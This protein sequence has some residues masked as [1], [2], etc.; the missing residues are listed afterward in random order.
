MSVHDEVLA[1]MH[2]M[3]ARFAARGLTLE[4]PPASSRL[5]GTKYVAVEMGKSLSGRF[6][7]NPAFGNPL[8]MYQGGMLGA[9]F[10]E[11]FGPLTYMAAQRPVVTLEMST[12]FVRPFMAADGW[13]EVAGQVVSQSRTVL[14]IQGEARTRDG[15]LVAAA[16]S[17]S[18]VL[19]DEQLGK[20]K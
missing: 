11:V 10:D 19:S 1:S 8:K 13:I 16:R 7:F 5:L 2:E 14:V 15:K 12:T 3:A 9:A 17:H 20:S 18:L 4:L 6:E